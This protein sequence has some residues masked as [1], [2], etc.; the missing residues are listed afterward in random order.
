MGLAVLW[1][2][3]TQGNAKNH[4]ELSPIRESSTQVIHLSVTHTKPSCHNPPNSG[5]FPTTIRRV[6]YRIQKAARGHRRHES[7]LPTTCISLDP[8]PGLFLLNR[9]AS[10]LTRM[11]MWSN[12]ICIFL[13]LFWGRVSLGCTVPRVTL[14]YP[15]VLKLL[16]IWTESSLLL[17][18]IQ[19]FLVWCICLP[20][21]T[22]MWVNV[23]VKRWVGGSWFTRGSWFSGRKLRL[24]VRGQLEKQQ[25]QQQELGPRLLLW[26]SFLT[27]I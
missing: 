13:D 12:K 25:Q 3:E 19:K 20:G 18:R 21:S 11:A 8:S 7:N 9:R 27:A 4:A 17:Q 16:C 10:L 15:Y 1:G 14:V 24:P 26:G 22:S 5:L 23:S 2:N 6:F